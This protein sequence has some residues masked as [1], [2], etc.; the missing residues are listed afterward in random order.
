[1]S[2]WGGLA[3]GCC[4][5]GWLW[6]WGR[7]W[8]G[9]RTAHGAPQRC[10]VLAAVAG[11]ERVPGAVACTPSCV[12]PF[13]LSSGQGQIPNPSGTAAVVR[14]GLGSPSLTAS[15]SLTVNWRIA[16]ATALA[17]CGLN[18]FFFF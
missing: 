16:G 11:L 3:S 7:P 15:W 8:V 6:G 17:F 18:V 10:R 9:D 1:M 2:P 5:G 12:C 4:G 14:A 13:T